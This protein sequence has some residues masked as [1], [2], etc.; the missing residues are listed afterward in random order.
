MEKL[1]GTI[2]HVLQLLFWDVE[3]F[4]LLL[5]TLTALNF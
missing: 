2:R 4:V 1:I 5:L 3:N